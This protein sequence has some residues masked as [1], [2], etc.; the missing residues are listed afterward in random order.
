LLIPVLLWVGSEVYYASRI[1]PHGV[2][3]LAE[4]YRRFGEPHRISR[5]HRDG[6]NYYELSG[7]ASGFPMIAFPSSPPAYVYDE[8]G[9]LVDWCPDPGDRAAY[10]ERWSRAGSQPVEPL[11]FRQKYGL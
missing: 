1:R 7:R 5:L 10:R 4:H 8:S 3:T 2:R 11:V 6:T 9:T